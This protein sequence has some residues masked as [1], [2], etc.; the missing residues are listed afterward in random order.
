[1]SYVTGIIAAALASAIV[2]MTCSGGKHEKLCS[3]VCLA[4]IALAALMPLRSLAGYISSDELRRDIAEEESRSGERV[5]RACENELE[6]RFAEALGI[7]FAG[8]KIESVTLTYDE[9]DIQNIK[10][11]SCLIA[12]DGADA[13]EV[14]DYAAEL[15]GCGSVTAKLTGGDR[16]GTQNDN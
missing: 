10:V 16:N 13:E 7:R 2:L 11:T 5:V 12:L 14:E 3:S 1:M 15:L 9:S 4:L 6:R 8:V